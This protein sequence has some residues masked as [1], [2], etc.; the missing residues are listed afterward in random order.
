M[1]NR[2][3]SRALLP[4]AAGLLLTPLA[5]GKFLPSG[6]ERTVTFNKAT[7]VNGTTVQ[8]AEYHIFVK[9]N[10]LKVE[11]LKDKTVAKSPVTWKHEDKQFNSTKMDID[12]GV[13]TKVEL[14]G[15]R[16]AVLLH[17]S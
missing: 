1:L 17:N 7:V 3:F 11:T 9:G 15:T 5:W 2:T 10:E 4:L 16:D 8:P 13:L 12:R 6:T 14:S